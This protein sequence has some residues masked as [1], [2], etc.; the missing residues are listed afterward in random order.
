M[1]IKL[2]YLMVIV[3]NVMMVNNHYLL[4][5]KQIIMNKYLLVLMNNI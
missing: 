4:K 2:K 3:K 1:L 5:E